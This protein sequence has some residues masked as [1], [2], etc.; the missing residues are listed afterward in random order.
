MIVI[1]YNLIHPKTAPK[2]S[3]VKLNCF[4]L[5][6]CKSKQEKQQQ[7]LQQKFANRKKKT[8]TK[9]KSKTF[10]HTLRLITTTTI[11]QLVIS[12]INN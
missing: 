8:K 7:L 4:H 1:E 3:A 12:S 11:A 6:A 2:P 5:D 9:N 10:A